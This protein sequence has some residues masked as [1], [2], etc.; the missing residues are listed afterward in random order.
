MLQNTRYFILCLVFLNNI[1]NKKLGFNIKHLRREAKIYPKDPLC[2]KLFFPWN[3]HA[4]SFLFCIT[5]CLGP[6]RLLDY[7]AAV[8]KLRLYVILY[9][10]LLALPQSFFNPKESYEAR[11]KEEAE[12]RKAQEEKREAQERK[13]LEQ[14][15]RMKEEMQKEE[16]RQAKLRKPDEK[17]P[18]W[19]EWPVLS[20]VSRKLRFFDLRVFP[21]A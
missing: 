16:E 4:I 21:F 3:V 18:V 9:I 15:E 1:F 13:R 8:Y 10:L 5:L 2:N 19:Q 17:P 20:Y 12:A 14:E 6:S 7:L 11:R